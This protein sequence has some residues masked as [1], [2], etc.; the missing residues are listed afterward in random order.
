[1]DIK[2]YPL[3]ADRWSDFESL[4]GPRGACG[5]CW[6]MYWKLYDN[7]FRSN[8]GDGNQNLQKAIV[9]AGISPGLI[10]YFNEIPVGWIAIEP[11]SN[12]L[13][14]ER[15]RILKP[16]DDED[17]WSISCFYVDRKYRLK[18]ITNSLITESVKF[19]AEKGA[20]I[21]EGYPT[22]TLSE[23]LPAPFVYTGLASGFFKAGF[24]EVARRSA[25]RPIM[26]FYIQ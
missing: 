1:M 19:A 22:D 3:T 21:V 5:G 9:A 24:K 17:V 25:K 14:L 15:S 10:A 11:R 6:C 4:F 18:G 13:R 2:I 8:R 7:D 20:K 16:V 12:Y 26:R 23:K